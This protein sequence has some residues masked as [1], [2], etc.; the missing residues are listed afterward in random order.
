MKKWGITALLCAMTAAAPARADMMIYPKF[1][2]FDD[3]TRVQEI[4]LTNP[5]EE[6]T[7][8]YRIRLK[9]AKQNPD[10]SYTDVEKPAFTTGVDLLRFSPRAAVLGPKKTQRVK[11]LKRLPENLPPGEYT[12]Y[13]V[14]TKIP[15]E[16]P[17]TKTTSAHGSGV[18]L[19][20]TAIPSFAI[21][22]I[23]SHG[24]QN[25]LQQS[26][27]QYLGRADGFDKTPAARIA[28]ERAAPAEMPASVTLRGDVSLWQNRKLIGVIK[29]KYLLAGNPRVEATVPLDADLMRPGEAVRVLFTVSTENDTIDTRRIL[30]QCEAV[31]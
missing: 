31:L 8:R 28:I 20:L 19:E 6:E 3:Q 30:A 25:T 4:T 16:K 26:V 9:Y 17:L 22:V 1:I 7:I 15:A 21:P 18:R 14:F 13:A 11:L 27:I 2:A 24:K 12:A 5:N 10:G 23:I 29:G